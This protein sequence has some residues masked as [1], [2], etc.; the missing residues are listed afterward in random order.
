MCAPQAWH[1]GQHR[2]VGL[3]QFPGEKQPQPGALCI[4]RKEW[5][6]QFALMFGRH[7]GAIVQDFELY[8]VALFM[9]ADLDAA[10]IFAAN[11]PG[12]TQQ[13]PQDLA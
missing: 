5:L 10:G 1:I 11:M 4:G 12:I 13:I 3:S 8:L 9:H 2:M 7:A 6:E